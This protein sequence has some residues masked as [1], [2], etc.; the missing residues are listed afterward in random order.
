MVQQHWVV[1]RM[2]TNARNLCNIEVW[3]CSALLRGAGLQLAYT[4]DDEQAMVQVE[5]TTFASSIACTSTSIP[6]SIS[7]IGPVL[8][9]GNR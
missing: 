6:I 1:H 8:G 4:L 3:S 5:G 2:L 7:P 9:M